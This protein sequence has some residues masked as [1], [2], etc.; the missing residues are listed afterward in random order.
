MR[1]L[2]F[3]PITIRSP[4]NQPTRSRAGGPAGPELLEPRIA[5]A[6][7]PNAFTKFTGEI[8]AVGEI[9]TFPFV[10][11]AKRA[12]DN[13][14]L[15]GGRLII[16]LCLSPALGSPL[17]PGQITVESVAADLVSTQRQLSNSPGTTD[18]F[19]LVKVKQGEFRISV[20]GEAGTVGTYELDLFLAG[21]LNNSGHIG[22]ADLDRIRS[23]HRT[24]FGDPK[25]EL[26]ADVDRNGRIDRR[27][28]HFAFQNLGVHTRLEVAVL[29]QVSQRAKGAFKSLILDEVLESKF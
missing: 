13:F 24:P 15:P 5:L 21:D 11:A 14:S 18:S 16:G 29:A 10:I 9:D 28:H 23:L 26:D 8:A 12:D 19:T 7:S 25:Y 27:D 4:R 6:C 20:S 22:F 3:T 1:R 2:I 17:D